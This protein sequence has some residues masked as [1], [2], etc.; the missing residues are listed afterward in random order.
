[1]AQSQR[2]R[3]K[4]FRTPIG[5]HDAYVA[6][7]S[8]KAALEAWGAQG[9]LFA[10]GI[11]EQ[12]TEA[13]LMEAP[14]A[15]PGTVI[16]RLRGT[17]SEQIAALG[18][19][20]RNLRKSEIAEPRA[21]KPARRQPAPKPSRGELSDAEEALQQMLAGQAEAREEIARRE[22]ALATERDQLERRQSQERQAAE[23]AV[24]DQRRRY[25]EAIARWRDG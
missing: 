21:Q 3:L 13:A 24:E 11:A 20:R 10:Q 14:L 9:N 19:A 7:P 12:V 23:K 15:E 22:R 25:E 4:V 17:E 6:A 2:Q 8:Q 5:F 16:K 1:L 18:K